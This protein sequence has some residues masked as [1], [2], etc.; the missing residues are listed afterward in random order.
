VASKKIRATDNLRREINQIMEDLHS[1]GGIASFNLTYLDEGISSFSW[2]R[3]SKKPLIEDFSRLSVQNYIDWASQSD[4]TALLLDGS[5][6]QMTY[7]MAGSVVV[8]HRLCYVPSPV[9]ESEIVA[10]ADPFNQW[11][12]YDFAALALERLLEAP[13][14]AALRSMIRFDYDPLNAK[15]GHPASHFTINSVDCRIPCIAPV[16]PAQ[17]VGFIFDNFYPKLRSDLSL[18]F[19]SLPALQRSDNLLE[20]LERT[21]MHF[22]W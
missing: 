12:G 14:S 9:I 8:G 18:F 1:L 10:K 7:K 21:S 19:E 5:L 2:Q 6:L 4:Y 17:F 16:S 13:E 20:D 15:P 22:S 3:V 11:L